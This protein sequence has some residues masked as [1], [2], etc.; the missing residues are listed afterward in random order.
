LL[1]SILPFGCSPEQSTSPFSNPTPQLSF[2]DCMPIVE[3]AAHDFV[4]FLL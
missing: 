2:I 4:L 1:C 3:Q